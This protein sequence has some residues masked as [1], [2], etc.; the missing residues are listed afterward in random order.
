MNSLSLSTQAEVCLSLKM[1]KS[2]N[3]TE[4]LILS[5]LLQIKKNIQFKQNVRNT[6]FHRTEGLIINHTIQPLKGHMRPF[7]KTFHNRD[8]E[9]QPD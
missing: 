6:Y 4:I 3:F 9:K 2:E 5:Q 8:V 7:H 1:S